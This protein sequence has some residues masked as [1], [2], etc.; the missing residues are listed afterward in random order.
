MSRVCQITGQKTSSGCTVSHSKRQVKRQVF[1]NLQSKRLLNP[2]TGRMMRL[3]VSTSA[4]KTLAKWQRAGK[5]YD[6]SK[7]IKN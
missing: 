3:T 7:L 6:L 2:A 5:K 1:S 4:L